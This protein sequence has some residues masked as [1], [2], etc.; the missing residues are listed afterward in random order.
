METTIKTLQETN[1]QTVAQSQQLKGTIDTLQSENFYLREVVFS[2]EN[3]LS[4]TGNA[5]I[6]QEVKAELYRRHY[7]KHTTRKIDGPTPPSAV[8]AA[9]EVPASSGAPTCSF[10]MAFIPNRIGGAENAST[11]NSFNTAVNTHPRNSP[12]QTQQPLDQSMTAVVTPVV[13][14]ASRT[15]SAI[16]AMPDIHSPASSPVNAIS[17]WQRSSHLNDLSVFNMNSE[18]L[19]KAPPMF[20]QSQ[21]QVADRRNP[22]SSAVSSEYERQDRD[23]PMD[24]RQPESALDENGLASTVYS[25]HVSVFDELQSSLFPPGTL[26]SIIHTSLATPQEIVDDI[27]LLDQLHDPR[28]SHHK[29][30]LIAPGQNTAHFQFAS[31]TPTSASSTATSS[32]SFPDSASSFLDDD[33][34]NEFRMATPT[35]G[36]DDGLKQEVIPSYRLQLE[37]RVLASAPP[38]V[39]PNIDPKIYA[40]PHDSRIDLIPCPKLRYAYTPLTRVYVRMKFTHIFS[41]LP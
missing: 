41:M 5:V 31:P 29:D 22:E 35:L 37:I 8:D 28:P 27:P 24:Q 19:Y 33:E 17:S 11:T 30:P 21:F 40:L 10:Q 18:I 2:F 14:T 3:A 13:H 15:E 7:D 6:L 26:Q 4:K 20:G 23:S 36:L 39:D 9:V 12:T 25:G 38:A 32:S 34:I 1:E 16:P